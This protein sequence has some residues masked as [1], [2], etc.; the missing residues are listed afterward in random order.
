MW[1]VCDFTENGIPQF[2]NS[3][4]VLTV[5][6][7]EVANPARVFVMQAAPV[8]IEWLRTNLVANDND[9]RVPTEALNEFQPVLHIGVFASL[10]TIQDENIKGSFGKEKLMGGMHDLLPAKVP[11]V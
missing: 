7:D 8:K 4:S 2:R 9:R 6:P 1:K 11:D 10:A 3:R 5:R